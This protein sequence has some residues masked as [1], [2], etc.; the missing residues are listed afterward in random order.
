M[1]VNESAP[2]VASGEIEV[3][4][5]PEVVWDVVADFDRWPAWNPDVQRLSL[6]GP[7]AE[8][9]EFRWRAGPSTIRSTLRT[10]ERPRRIG[11][12]GKTPGLPRAVHLWWFEP[13]DGHTL[14]RT[15]ESW[16]GLLPRLLRGPMLKQL[17]KGIDGGLRHL[18]A[19]AE[20]RAAERAG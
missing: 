16:E 4:A 18:K 1:Q 9:T 14:A 15:S 11:W 20:R 3:A 6:H 13:K 17:Q 19:E 12:T 5:P 8:G 2:V 10:V 7:V